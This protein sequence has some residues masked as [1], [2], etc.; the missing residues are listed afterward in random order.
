MAPLPLL[1]IREVLSE[2]RRFISS[3]PKLISPH[4][5][6]NEHQQRR[7]PGHTN[8]S[9]ALVRVNTDVVAMLVDCVDHFIDDD[10]RDG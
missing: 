4:E 5:P 6:C 10:I 2:D 9:L 7:C 8:K 3:L 1:L